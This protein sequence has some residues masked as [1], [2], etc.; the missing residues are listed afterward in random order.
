LGNLSFAAE[1]RGREK[2][3]S[4][5]GP[6]PPRDN[7]VKG[8]TSVSLSG[9]KLRYSIN[10]PKWDPLGKR[11]SPW[12]WV[13]AFDGQT[14]KFLQT[15]AYGKDYPLG[16]V[17]KTKA[18]GADL[19]TDILPLIF[20]IRGDHPQFFHELRLFKVSGRTILVAGRPCLEMVRE[21][22]AA[23]WREVLFLDR[24]RDYVVVRQATLA[25]D[26]PTSQVDVT[27]I[28]DATIGWVPQ[29]WEY[30]VRAGKELR[31]VESR[32]VQLTSYDLHPQLDESEFDVS[33]P[34]RTL[35][36]DESSSQE[37]EYVIQEDGQK[38]K[39]IPTS[40]KPTYEDLEKATPKRSNRWVLIAI[41]TTIL[42]LSL[43]GWVW[44]R[45]QRTTRVRRSPQ[46]S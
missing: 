5:S 1:H 30:V 20:T 31:P 6:N 15:P 34:P 46:Q 10:Q 19:Q 37:V 13:G 18:S 22:G 23:N 4:D 14:H 33:F 7:L 17:R 35:V 27:Y 25:D 26:Q 29:S 11:L 24:D 36:I 43:G 16:R 44:L 40:K 42:L 3:P 39:E 8:T 41:W 45:R 12:Q 32:R 2:P 9:P 21:A 38:G 28:P